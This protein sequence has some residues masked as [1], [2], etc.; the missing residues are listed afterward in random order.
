MK[1]KSIW[2][3]LRFGII[4]VMVCARYLT[5][6]QNGVRVEVHSWLWLHLDIQILSTL[7]YH[8]AELVRG[9]TKI[10]MKIT[11]CLFMRQLVHLSGS[12]SK[13]MHPSTRQIT[14]TKGAWIKV[15]LYFLPWPSVSPDL[16]PME[17]AW[18]LLVLAVYSNGKQHAQI[19]E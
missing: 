15:C 16:K 4:S 5:H 11:C 1:R 17:N 13:R 2:I 7:R 19:S 3:L 10:Y 8:L 14:L 18:R 12:S 6:F 9:A